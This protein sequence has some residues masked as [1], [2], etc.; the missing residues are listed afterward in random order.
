V[1]AGLITGDPSDA[2]LLNAQLPLQAGQKIDISQLLVKLENDIRNNVAAAI[3]SG[4]LNV[5]FGAPNVQGAGSG[6]ASV[7]FFFGNNSQAQIECYTAAQVIEAKGLLDTIGSDDFNGLGYSYYNI[8]IKQR[9][10]GSIGD[11]QNGDW[12]YFADFDDYETRDQGGS[13]SGENVIKLGNDSFWG[14]GLGQGDHS[15]FYDQILENYNI[16]THQ[17][18]SHSIPGFNGEEKFIDV[19]VMAAHLFELRNGKLPPSNCNK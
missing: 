11:L 19:A 16:D 9:T 14:F 1:L 8:P 7:N 3:N 17:N 5:G 2:G 13:W 15:Y 12:T 10:V 18:V 4:Q 6:A